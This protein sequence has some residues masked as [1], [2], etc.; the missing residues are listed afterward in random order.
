ML[1]PAAVERVVSWCRHGRLLAGS[2]SKVKLRVDGMV[3]PYKT[4]WEPAIINMT[5][6]FVRRTNYSEFGS[7]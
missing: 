5:V 7:A 4:V 1:R 2:V 6:N 3:V